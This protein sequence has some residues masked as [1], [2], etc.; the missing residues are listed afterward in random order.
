MPN[1]NTLVTLSDIMEK[2]VTQGLNIAKK[3]MYAKPENGGIGLFD[4]KNFI[5]AL[6]STW[7]KRAFQCCNDN[8]KFD[9]I[10][11]YE[12]CPHKVGFFNNSL[13]KT[14]NNIAKSF[15]TFAEDFAKVKSNYLHSP[16][17]NN[18][19]FGYGNGG[20]HHFDNRF[21]EPIGAEN[22]IDEITWNDLTENNEF[23]TLDMVRVILG[24]GIS[25]EKY[26]FLQMGWNRAKKKFHVEGKKGTKLLDFI[27]VEKKVQQ[28]FSHKK[29]QSS[30]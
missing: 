22:N 29:L 5:I 15:R 4:L 12:N 14:L 18:I 26:R 10:S 28:D 19:L 21:F 13:G 20:V 8:W 9:L 16:I 2:F 23:K 1:E 3:R 24:N 7:A 11:T 17:L 6:Q 27:S 25:I 30:R